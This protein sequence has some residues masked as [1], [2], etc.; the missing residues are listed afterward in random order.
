MHDPYIHQPNV[1]ATISWTCQNVRLCCR[2]H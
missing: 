1:A 2:A